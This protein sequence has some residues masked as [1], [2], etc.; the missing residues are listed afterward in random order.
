[1]K[2]YYDILGVSQYATQ[3][4]IKKAYRRIAM[5]NHPDRHPNDSS[6]EKRFKEATEA[7]TALVKSNPSGNEFNFSSEEFKNMLKNKK[8]F[9]DFLEGLD[10]RSKKRNN[11][12]S[13]SISIREAYYG[14]TKTIGSDTVNITRGVR[15]NAKIVS[16][17]GNLVN[18]LIPHDNFW[19]R[20]L[21]DLM[22][23]VKITAFEAMIGTSAVI[24]HLDGK[25]YKFKIPAGTQHGGL[26][27]IT[28]KGM[29][30]PTFLGRFGDLLIRCKVE[31]PK[32]LSESEKSM[33]EQIMNKR[34]INI[35]G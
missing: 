33:I 18:I 20:N 13:V 17:S 35:G 28:G 1:M 8:I 34:E 26:I 14:T 32:H 31:I 29:P 27:R 24:K 9:D 16:T 2:N 22:C 10:I 23:D 12:A 3:E 15:N 6:A 4:E 21:D 30:N 7:Y 5:K 25:Q 11:V 19:E